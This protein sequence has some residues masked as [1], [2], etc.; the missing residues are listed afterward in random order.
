MRDSLRFRDRELAGKIT[1]SIHGLCK[2]IGRD[3]RIMEVCGTHTVSLRKHGIHSLIPDTVRLVSGPGCPVCVTPTGYVDNALLLAESHGCRIATFGDMLRVPGSDGRTLEGL[4]GS[5][6]VQVVYSPAEAVTPVKA[7][8]SGSGGAPT[9]FLGIGF[10]T[11][12]PAVVSAA[13]T[14]WARGGDGAWEPGEV[15]ANGRPG[16]SRGPLFLYTAFKTVPPALRALLAAP[17]HGLDGFLL[18]GH[19]SVII[20]TSAY[21][22]LSEPGGIPGVV[23]GFEPIDMLLGIEGLLA[24]I[25]DGRRRVGNAYPRAVR[26]QGNPKARRL[27]QDMLGPYDAEWRG[28]GVIP[29]SGLRLR[30]EWAEMDAQRVFNLPSVSAPEPKGCRCAE[31]IQG[32]TIP[33][34]CPLFG[35][36]CTPEDPVGPCMVSSEGTC[37]AYLRYGG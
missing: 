19:V 12:I 33:P 29:Q 32:R 4:M 16:A 8:A 10:E 20:G 24:D 3:V 22:F 5:G 27:M 25:R 6:R 26:P 9:V 13:A 28:L 7:V 1:R 21:E 31:V 14:A 34:Q 37:A 15:S 35:S 17:D 30:A 23:T 36:D 18:P 2:D 11:T